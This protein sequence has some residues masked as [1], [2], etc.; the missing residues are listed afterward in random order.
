[1]MVINEALNNSYGRG[2]AKEGRSKRCK[3]VVVAIKRENC[4]WFL[5]MAEGIGEPAGAFR[6]RRRLYY[7]MS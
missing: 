1:M 2:K 7:I 5:A 3:C 4:G 6:N